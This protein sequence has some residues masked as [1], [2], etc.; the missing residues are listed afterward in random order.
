MLKFSA[1]LTLMFTE[2]PFLERFGA[3][4]AAGFRA[5]EFLFPLEWPVEELAERIKRYNLQVTLMN[6]TPG[7]WSRG[8][9]GLACVPDRIAEFR[10]GVEQT[11]VYAKALECTRLHCVAG[12]VPRNMPM[13]HVEACY[14]DNVL[15][16]ADA[17]AGAG[18]EL[19]IEPINT[20][21]TPGY[22]LDTFDKAMTLMNIMADRGGMQP[23]LQF[24]I[25]HCA[26]IHGDVPGWI[27]RCGDR[28]G[29]FQIAGIPDRHEPDVGLL[30]TDQIFAA[31]NELGVDTWIGCEY[32]PK[33]GT[34]DGLG[35][36]EDVWNKFGGEGGS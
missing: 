1:N 6:I 9:R 3:V 23:K 17:C 19:L 32:H 29:Y 27:E 11:L 22:F 15:L 4:S 26:K 14:I 7:D 20:G 33:D 34:F 5:V 35:W 30:P 2:R 28:V 8:D 25:Y 16:A 31:V 12:V 13:R 10:R 21:D 18:V 24:D 36:I